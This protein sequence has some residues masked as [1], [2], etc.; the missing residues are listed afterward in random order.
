VLRALALATLLAATTVGSAAAEPPGPGAQ[1]LIDELGRARVTID[2][3]RGTLRFA[4]GNAIT[5][6]AGRIRLGRPTSPRAAARAY[7]DD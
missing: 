5:P 1:A 4:R 2:D 7:M 3:D 6:S